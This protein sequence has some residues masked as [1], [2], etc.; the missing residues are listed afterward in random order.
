MKFYWT[1]LLSSLL[2]SITGQ[3]QVKHDSSSLKEVVIK[4]YFTDQPLLRAPSSISVVSSATLANHAPGS[5][6]PALNTVPGL[7]MEERSPGSYRLSLRGSLLRSPFG[8]RNVKTYLNDF[9]LTDAGG[10]TYLNVLDAAAAARIEVLKGPEGSV[11]GANSGG[12]IVI[13]TNAGRIDSG[14]LSAS[15]MGGSYGMFRESLS[16]TAG[17]EKLSWNVHQAFQRAEGYRENSALNRKYVQVAPEWHYSAKG[18]VRAL[19][20]FSDLNYQTPGGLT[21]QQYEQNPERARPRAGNSPGAIE[22]QAQIFNQTLLGG[23]SHQ[24]N[25]SENFRH[26]IALTT[27][28]TDFKNPF[29]TNF[30]VRDEGSAGVRSY[31]EYKNTRASQ[32]SIQVGGELQS[33]YTG[34]NRFDNNGGE[35]GSMQKADDLKASQGFLFTH[36]SLSPVKNLLLESAL[37]VNKYQYR[38]SS[39]FPAV[40]AATERRFDLEWM[41]RFALSYLVNSAFALRASISRGYSAPTLEEINPS[42][43]TVNTD[44]QAEK[45]WNRELGYRLSLFNNRLYWDAVVFYYNLQDAIVRGVEA[46]DNTFYRNAGGT[47][48]RGLESELVW[49]L[50][51]FRPTS[52]I[53]DVQLRNS[54][55]YSH[56]KFDNY[57]QGTDDF[58]RNWLTGVPRHVIVTSVELGLPSAISL[59]AQHNYTSKLPLNDA[60]SVYAE[61]YHLIDL[62]ASYGRNI[63]RSK[64]EFFLGINNLLNQRYS[65]G[66]DLNAFGGRYFNAAAPLNVYGGL[67]YRY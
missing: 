38:F 47:K 42:P 27:S 41:P 32:L 62:K 4:A 52:F 21:L 50:L 35:R 3:A 45:G 7:R 48:Q 67:S 8:I 56:F 58:S 23:L 49:S 11:F 15:L 20:L 9:L 12:V 34:I 29:I 26:V 61:A 66:N 1:I 59:F 5:L 53:Q 13:N 60:N 54:Y 57:Q 46:N 30:E 14:S 25:F 31:V 44:L 16:L 10:N 63:R 39:S 33:S 64:V 19:A 37:S 28:R 24:Y 17:N 18:R 43:T 51:P 55:T 2:L 22:Q 36:L 40:L 65:L 6:V